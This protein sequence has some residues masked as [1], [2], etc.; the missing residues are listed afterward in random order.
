MRVGLNEALMLYSLQSAM[1][2]S[3]SCAPSKLFSLKKERSFSRSLKSVR[4]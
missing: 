2:S 4:I 1:R 3:I